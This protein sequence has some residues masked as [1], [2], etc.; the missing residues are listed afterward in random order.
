M[1]S[2]RTTE[3][4][5]GAADQGAP[6]I[7]PGTLPAR[8]D[9]V[10]ADV[11]AHLLTGERLTGLDAVTDSSTTRLSAVVH[12]LQADYGWQIGREDRAAG[13]R[14]GRVAWVTEYHLSDETRRHA[15]AAGAAEWC[16]DVR[17]ARAALRTEAANARSA[18][19]R[20]NARQ[21][22][23]KRPPLGQAGRLNDDGA[24]E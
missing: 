22:A 11:L 24:Q 17:R 12:R 18:A 23:R 13:C 3:V 14:D 6:I 5:A 9:T 16:A 8:Q 10:T 21:A 15:L 7:H 19:D 20:A 4:N 2:A 1:K